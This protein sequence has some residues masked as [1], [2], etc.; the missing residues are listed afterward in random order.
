M[1]QGSQ[2]SVPPALRDPNPHLRFAGTGTHV[3]HIHIYA[4]IPKNKFKNYI[5][6]IPVKIN[7]DNEMNISIAPKSRYLLAQVI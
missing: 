4:H 7:R 3:A 1:P 5:Y 6:Y 2:L